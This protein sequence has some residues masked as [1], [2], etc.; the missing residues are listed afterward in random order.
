[1]Y[2]KKKTI[3]QPTTTRSNRPKVNDTTCA[4]KSDSASAAELPPVDAVE[5]LRCDATKKKRA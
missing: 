1:M 5:I 3:N 2:E 4:S